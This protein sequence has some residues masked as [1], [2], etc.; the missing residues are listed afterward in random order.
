MM[1]W[2][3]V[4]FIVCAFGFSK[5]LR[6]SEAYLTAFLTGPWKNLTETEVNNEIYPWWTYSYLLWLVPMLL[7]TDYLRYKPIIIL[8]GIAAVVTWVILLWAQG[9][10]AMRSM[11]VTFGLATAC[12]MG[13]YSYLFAVVSE[14]H[15]QKVS[16]FT[17]AASLFGRF[18]GYLCGQLFVSFDLLDL[19]QLNIFSF[20]SVTIGLLI[21]IILPRAEYSELFNPRPMESTDCD[22]DEEKIHDRPKSFRQFIRFIVGEIKS[23]YSNRNVLIWSIWWAFASCGSF[24]IANYAQNLWYVLT[25]Y[26]NDSK[27]RHLYNG[28]V[29]AAGTFFSTCTV[30]LIGF[31]PIDWSVRGRCELLMCIVCAINTVMLFVMATTSSIW[32]CYIMYDLFRASYQI[33]ITIATAQIAKHLVKQRYGFVFGCNTFLALLIETILTLIVVDQ[34]GLG[35]DVQ[36]QFK[37]YGGYFGAMTVGFAAT[38]FWSFLRSG[39][40]SS[41]PT[42]TLEMRDQKDTENT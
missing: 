14:S 39:S 37:V 17:R 10:P 42:E 21:S 28:A 9:V 29:D 25:P 16:S 33:V 23:I 31:I 30:L 6:P 2:R 38:W 27:Q 34:S 24:Q 41:R 4:C 19:F 13:Y 22:S 5:D 1:D 3:I 18:V 7:L 15:Y 8:N 26:K 11:Q 35:L 20:V 32:V 40:N 36:T 12:E